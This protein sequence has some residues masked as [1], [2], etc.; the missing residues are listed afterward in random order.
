[1]QIEVT[2]SNRPLPVARGYVLSMT[3]R[4][5]KGRR[6]VEVHLY[7]SAWSKDEVDAYNW[8]KI[9]GGSIER[10]GAEPA[11]PDGSKKVLLEAFT[12]EERDLILKY[13][14]ETYASRLSKVTAMPLG[15]PIPRGLM[16]L[17]SFPEGKSIGIIKLDKIPTYPLPFK[18]RGLYDLSLH[19]PMVEEKAEDK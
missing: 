6:D 8:S 15:F 4:S 16:P 3:I 2:E 17:S 18:M 10:K 5:F 19:K 9:L 13:L 12:L 1:M 7:R 11:D 14:N